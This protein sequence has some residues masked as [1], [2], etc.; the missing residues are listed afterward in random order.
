MSTVIIKKSGKKRVNEGNNN[1]IYGVYMKSVLERKVYL[2]ITE[3]G[4]TVKKNLELKLEKTLSGKCVNEG[5]I[6]PNSIE[7]HKYS[8]G[9]VNNDVIEFYVVFDAMVCLPIEGMLIDCICKTITKAGIHAEVI[10]D[11][12]NVPIT[13]FIAHDHHHLDAKFS[14]IKENNTIRASVIGIRYELDDKFICTIGKLVQ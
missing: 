7:I 14:E 13:M 3:V 8:S 11:Q 2:N 9:V 6:K 4:K 12:K 10:D 1:D 5:F